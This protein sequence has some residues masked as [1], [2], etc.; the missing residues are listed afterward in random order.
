MSWWSL[1]GAVLS[2][3]ALGSVLG[4]LLDLWFL[5]PQ[6]AK[7]EQR[8]WLRAARL[9]AFAQ[10]SAELMSFGTKSGAALDFQRLRAISA[11]SELLIDDPVL[12]RDLRSL[13]GDMFTWNTGGSPGPLTAAQKQR[14]VSIK[15]DDGTEL[16]DFTLKLEDGT[17]LTKESIVRTGDY[18][19]LEKRADDLVERLGRAARDV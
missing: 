10:F 8:R 3:A 12:L 6:R 19:E 13:I 1:A 2:G 9:E 15:L 5:E 18:M 7:V 16:K 14:G 11:R 17:L 4:K